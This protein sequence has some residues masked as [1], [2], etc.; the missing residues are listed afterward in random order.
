[1]V[2]AAHTAPTY[3]SWVCRLKAGASVLL[4]S[5]LFGC[6]G[7]GSGGV[8]EPEPEASLP[9]LELA[10]SSTVPEAT[11]SRV[12]QVTTSGGATATAL[13]AGTK[14]DV[15]PA[16]ASPLVLATNAQGQL[17]L[18]TLATEKELSA[19]NTA[20]ALLWMWMKPVAGS[21]LDDK[22]FAATARRAAGF[23]TLVTQIDAALAAGASPVNSL[24]VLSALGDVAARIGVSATPQAE[25]MRPLAQISTPRLAGSAEILHS[26]ENSGGLS[27]L[28]SGG[29]FVNDASNISVFNGTALYWSAYAQ[30][31]DGRRVA[32]PELL[33]P[34][35]VSDAYKYT[36]GVPPP[37]TGFI[38]VR[39]HPTVSYDFVVT[40]DS[41]ASRAN[42]VRL[43][44][45][46]L[47]AIL[48]T[49]SLLFKDLSCV[50]KYVGAVARKEL[51]VLA[52]KADVDAVV[53]Y[54]SAFQTE[55]AKVGLESLTVSTACGGGP[56]LLQALTK[57]MPLI[58]IGLAVYRDG[59][60][61]VSKAERVGTAIGTWIEL[62]EQMPLADGAE[63][64]LGVCV[65]GGR[66]VTCAKR[67]QLKDNHPWLEG[68]RG[69]LG[70]DAFNAPIG[71]E[72]TLV[73]STLRISAQTLL[74]LTS[75]PDAEVQV[76]N[77]GTF[78]VRLQDDPTGHDSNTVS[79]VV[80]PGKI[81]Y[82]S[83][84]GSA[85]SGPFGVD[86]TRA[87]AVVSN[88]AD[89]QFSSDGGVSFDW[90]LAPGSENIVEL[91]VLGSR[92]ASVK[93]LK[94]GIATVQAV[95]SVTG[96]SLEFAIGVDDDSPYWSG[97]YVIT[98]C[99]NGQYYWENPCNAYGMMAGSY[100]AYFY[101]RDGFDNVIFGH[102]LGS[103]RDDLRTVSTLGWRSSNNAFGFDLDIAY[104]ENN[105]GLDRI[106]GFGTRKTRFLT[107]SRTA[108]RISGT[109]TIETKSG[110]FA[111]NG[112]ITFPT[113][114]SGQWSA[115]LRRGPPPRT[116]MMGKDFCDSSNMGVLKVEA[117]LGN[118]WIL[119][120]LGS[121]LGPCRF[122]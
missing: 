119:P 4:V 80:E 59:F 43:I 117:D 95:N 74:P 110:T 18:A 87:L 58:Q 1:M 114:A 55:V 77:D 15:S 69:V 113:F 89:G 73:P 20:M 38:N 81:Q 121:S 75:G 24:P 86:Q 105:G 14:V 12:A 39:G 122:N 31:A 10:L 56:T 8:K 76:L 53:N 79:L 50:D 98:Q 66:V 2:V 13:R 68:A 7:G 72:S 23:D 29:I 109:F 106:R 32:E 57:Q 84:L 93:A 47:N 118:P 19:S 28:I 92:L 111:D 65:A 62:A 97:S 61:K 41:A 48:G 88:S 44:R 17:M 37:S 46:A 9:R 25:R 64:K 34:V 5:A 30:G 49:T 101:F 22:T 67:Y 102:N 85:T 45:T 52:A 21:A 33:L 83:F 112:W 103:G 99:Q 26:G 100:G 16:D 60:A 107:T 3:S 116:D 11:V 120:S 27:S 63:K 91:G 36:G 82:R 78:P 71:G 108:T 6:G 54:L 42:A 115:D 90:R 35:S 40:Q 96:R 104:S 94:P 51:E 70:L